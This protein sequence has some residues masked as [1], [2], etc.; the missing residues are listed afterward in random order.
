MTS[1]G[2]IKTLLLVVIVIMFGELCNVV[3][4]ILK[5]QHFCQRIFNRKK[6]RLEIP[7]RLRFSQ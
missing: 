7:S 2:L 5:L 4:F 1:K 6:L 3:D